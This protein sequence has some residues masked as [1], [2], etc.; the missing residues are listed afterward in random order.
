MSYATSILGPRYAVEQIARGIQY[1]SAGFPEQL[2]TAFANPRLVRS[3]VQALIADEYPLY[4]VTGVGLAAVD[5]RP[6]IVVNLADPESLRGRLPSAMDGVPIVLKQTGTEE[7]APA[8]AI[9]ELGAAKERVKQYIASQ[10]IP[11]VL[12]VGIGAGT[13]VV[14]AENPTMLRPY[15]PTSMDGIPVEVR[16]GGVVYASGGQRHRRYQLVSESDPELAGSECDLGSR[17]G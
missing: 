15:L 13:I 11:G 7:W 3:K 5:G 17:R 14:N 8:G 1:P 16:Q 9:D 10:N 4:G 6:V 2:Y 12:G